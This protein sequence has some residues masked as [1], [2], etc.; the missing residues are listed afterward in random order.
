MPPLTYLYVAL[1]GAIGSVGRA[2]VSAGMARLAGPAF[3][4]GTLAVNVLGSF[5]IGLFGT[6]TLSD[7]RF[8]VASD[9][10][11]FVMIGICGG[12]TTFSSFSLQTLDLARDGRPAQAL[13]NIGL[14]LVLCLVSVAAGHYTAARLNEARVTAPA[15]SLQAPI[16]ALLTRPEATPAVLAAAD[17]L[18]TLGGGL[19]IE[20]LTLRR[21]PDPDFLP[22]EDVLTEASGAAVPIGEIAAHSIIVASPPGLHPALFASGRP[23]LIVPPAADAARLGRIVA[24]AWRDDPHCRAALAAA[25]PILRRA[26]QVHILTAGDARATPALL[27]AERIPATCHVLPKGGEPVGASLLGAAALL[28]AD[29]FV[30]GAYAH[31]P[32][33]EAL[34]GGVTRYVLQHA[35]LPVLMRHQ[36]HIAGT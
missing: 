16:L 36:P 30:M 28:E 17:R 19:R 10:R 21:W 4:W 2:A 6:L 34:F 1:G 15:T 22:S 33:R 11:A 5:V 9:W 7:G 35:A 13:G 18:A 3:P 29:L 23:V 25:A 27:D 8:P 26:G 14:S 24:V 20:R 12:F 31:G 32:F